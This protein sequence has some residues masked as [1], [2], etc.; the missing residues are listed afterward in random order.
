MEF[1]NVVVVEP[2]HVAA[3]DKRLLYVALTRPIS[4]LTLIHTTPLPAALG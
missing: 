4:H 3:M 2:S 1:D